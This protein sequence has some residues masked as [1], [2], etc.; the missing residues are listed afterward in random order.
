MSFIKKNIDKILIMLCGLIFILISVLILCNR[1]SGFDN[2]IYKYVSYFRNNNL[3]SF[4]K[5]ISF[6][7]STWYIVIFSLLLVIISKKNRLYFAINPICCSLLNQILKRIF[8]RPRPI[9][10][11]LINES[12]Y[13]FPS[14]HSMISVVFYGFFM[15]LIWK[16]DWKLSIKLL[17]SIPL[18]ILIILVGISR[19]Y[20]GVHFASDVIGAYMMGIIVLYTIIKKIYNR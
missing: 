5:V 12:G 11:N 20:L 6:L 1:I 19:I 8:R 7:A 18:G 9:L 13:S 15:Y 3:T 2:Y 10:I 16:K 14:G 4:F 17:L